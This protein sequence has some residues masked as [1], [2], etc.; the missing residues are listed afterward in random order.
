M[1]KNIK[2]NKISFP[3]TIVSSTNKMYKD[4]PVTE[5]KIR[6]DAA[7]LNGKRD[8]LEAASHAP[9]LIELTP[10]EQEMDLDGEPVDS[11][12]KLDVEGK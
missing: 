7:S 8:A 10:S 5:L 12:T 11:Q 6:V 9:A 2:D 1:T 4:S 3:A